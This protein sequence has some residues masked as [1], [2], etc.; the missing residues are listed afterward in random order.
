MKSAPFIVL[1]FSLF[2]AGE[3]TGQGKN[4]Y[5]SKSGD[6]SRDGLSM[7]TAWRS[8]DKISN[9]DFNPGDSLMLEG[10]VEF[11]GTISLASDDNGSPG[12]PVV[13]T[14]YGN[15]KATIAAG[16]G[17]G[18]QANNTSFIRIVSL[19]FEG[20]GVSSNKGNG[21]HFFANDS[22]NSPSDIEVIDCDVRGFKTF[23]IGF[24]ANDNISY[25]G[26]RN[27]RIIHCNVSENGQ[28][29]ISSYGSYLG[30]QHAHFYISNCKVFENRGI[31]SRTESHTGNGI[32]MAMIDDLLIEYCE[33]YRNGADNR[34]TA[35]GPVGIWVWMCKNAVIQYCVSHDNYAG[36]TKD[37][38]GFDIDGGASN[39]TLQYNYSYN[40]EGAG[41][42]L[43]EYGAVFPYTNNIVRFNISFNDGR[44]NGYGGVSIWGAGKEYRVT[45]T[46][47]YNN[48]IYLDDRNIVNGRPAGINL[49]GPNFSNVIA[50]NNI[51]ATKGNVSVISSDTV[52]NESAF[53][54]LHNNYYSFSNLYHFQMGKNKFN[55]IQAWLSETPN[56]EKLK[57]KSLWMNLDPRFKDQHLLTALSSKNP[58]KY[59]K[60]GLILLPGS[61]LRTKPFDL[62]DHFNILSNTKDYCNNEL[63]SDGKVIP[64]A[65]TR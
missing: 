5:V 40:N 20:S 9:F 23:G 42:L 45:N 3:L 41:Y 29:G 32:V 61:P 63:S 19:K 37:G 24:G 59:F 1:C 34:C 16:D 64:G 57:G 62:G 44:K 4:Y 43:A 38:G 27:V 36:L 10:G 22:L 28:A 33:A 17:E 58:E 12:K 49:I 60:K 54:L 18:L 53:L 48:T 2:V 39:C 65:C 30:F 25:K 21:I 6:D 13:V 35:G 11:K 7:Q 31:P 50:A 47:I 15:K 56:Q 26:Y 55:S 14:S 52:V 46:Y 51:I 8:L